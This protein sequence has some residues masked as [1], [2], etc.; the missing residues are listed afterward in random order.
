M[1]R[2]RCVLSVILKLFA[3]AFACEENTA[4]HC[5]E[6]ETHLFSDLAVLISGHIHVERDAVVIAERI[7][8][9]GDLLYG[10]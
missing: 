8:R 4:L 3:E 10:I 1:M 7:Q 5:A 9:F 6:G 2:H